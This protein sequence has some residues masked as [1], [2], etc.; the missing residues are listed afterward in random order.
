MGEWAETVRLVSA[1]GAQA[2]FPRNMAAI[3]ANTLGF[4][5]EEQE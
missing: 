1:S 5:L 4:Q 2:F 3:S